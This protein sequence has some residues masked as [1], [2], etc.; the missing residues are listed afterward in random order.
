M[1]TSAGRTVMQTNSVTCS[2]FPCM[3]YTMYRVCQQCSCSAAQTT[4][5]QLLDTSA[6]APFSGHTSAHTSGHF[7]EHFLQ[8]VITC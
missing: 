3:I 2:L 7:R 4:W 1:Q 8:Y 6:R 5:L